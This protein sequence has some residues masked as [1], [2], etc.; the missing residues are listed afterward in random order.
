LACVLLSKNIQNH[1]LAHSITKIPLPI[2]MNLGTLSVNKQ[3]PF[4]ILIPFINN[5]NKAIVG[6][7]GFNA[8]L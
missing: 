3:L 2:F 8:E 5:T 7:V 4:T 6:Y 1:V